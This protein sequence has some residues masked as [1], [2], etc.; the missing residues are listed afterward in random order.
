MVF[1]LGSEAGGLE[2]RNAGN[3]DAL[4]LFLRRLDD[5]DSPQP[6]G[7]SGKEGGV[8]TAYRVVSD[9]GFGLYSTFD[10]GRPKRVTGMPGRRG[11][12]VSG[13]GIEYSFPK[14]T[15]WQ[16]EPMAKVTVE[17][18]R[19][20]LKAISEFDNFDDAGGAL[21]AAAVRKAFEAKL[22]TLEAPAAKSGA[23]ESP[24]PRG[25][26][27]AEAAGAEGTQQAP[28]PVQVAAERVALEQP[29]LKMRMG[30]DGEGNPIYKTV[31]EF[32]EDAK[33]AADDARE[34]AALFPLAAD[35]LLSGGA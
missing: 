25:Q 23:A 29:D 34:D 4:G 31:K 14:D 20:A 11:G 17:E 15:G 33:A 24:P 9:K 26:K 19:A 12:G 13:R 1:R 2:N 5:I 32:L 18:V 10:Q 16:A 8:I 7:R 3:A 21:A 30:T 27:P 22:S 28:D 6:A 35:C